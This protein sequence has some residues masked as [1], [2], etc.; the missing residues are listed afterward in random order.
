[1]TEERIPPSMM[2]GKDVT[3]AEYRKARLQHRVTLI[4]TFAVPLALFLY[5]LLVNATYLSSDGPPPFR[6]SIAA[7]LAINRLLYYTLKEGRKMSTMRLIQDAEL[8]KYRKTRAQN[9]K[10]GFGS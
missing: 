8:K 2:L 4:A 9:L 6:E 1:M 3:E 5:W 7:G 10:S